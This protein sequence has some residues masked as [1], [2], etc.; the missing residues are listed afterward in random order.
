MMHE[1]T[2]VN[3][4]WFEVIQLLRHCDEAFNESAAAVTRKGRPTNRIACISHMLCDEKF[5]A[6][7]IPLTD[8]VEPAARPAEL[9]QIKATGKTKIDAVYADIHKSYK[10]WIKDYKNPFVDG[11]W[12]S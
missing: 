3:G 2:P 1:I 5:L 10:T 12:A 4:P 7:I 9:D 11:L 6:C 8:V